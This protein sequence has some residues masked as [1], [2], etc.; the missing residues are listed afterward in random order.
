QQGNTARPVDD[1]LVCGAVYPNPTLHKRIENTLPV[2]LLEHTDRDR[3]IIKDLPEVR[4][5]RL[6][7]SAELPKRTPAASDE[8][9]ASLL[10]ER[11][12]LIPQVSRQPVA[13]QDVIE[14]V[15]DHEQAPLLLFELV[16]NQ[17]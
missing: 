12:K 5:S 9:Q 2:P 4:R 17:D 13:S 8:P 3:G 11:A 7:G 1:L 15:E 16:E 6:V 10:R 14:S